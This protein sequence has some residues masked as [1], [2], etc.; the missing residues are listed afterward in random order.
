MGACHILVKDRPGRPDG[1]HADHREHDVPGDLDLL[2]TNEHWHARDIRLV[3]DDVNQGHWASLQRH[4]LDSVGVP[5]SRAGR[6]L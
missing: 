2:P 3:K 4:E 6:V 1:G 5:E